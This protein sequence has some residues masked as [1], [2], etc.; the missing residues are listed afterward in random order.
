MW[1]RLCTNIAICIKGNATRMGK[2]KGAFDH[3]A[4]RVPTGKVA[5]EVD[6]MHE[7][8]AKDALRR[9]SDKLPGV[10]EFIDKTTPPRLG[11]KVVEEVPKPINYLDELKKNPT[12]KYAN[13]LKSKEPQYK[14]FTGRRG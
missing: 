5:F 11:L 8:A 13:Y 1:K 2:G 3:W 14:H 12:K 6:N 7:A 4:A 9:C 10:W